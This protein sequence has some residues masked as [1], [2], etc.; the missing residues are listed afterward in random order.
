MKLPL[1]AWSQEAEAIVLHVVLN[2]KQPKYFGFL[3]LVQSVLTTMPLRDF[4]SKAESYI[5]STKYAIRTQLTSLSLYL[6][7]LTPTWFWIRAVSSLLIWVQH[8]FTLWLIHFY[9]WYIIIV[10]FLIIMICY[11]VII[12]ALS[13]VMYVSYSLFI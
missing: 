7:S 8:F 10:F 6:F 3:I 4:I 11:S 9:D 12:F 5:I 13:Q 2:K 1:F